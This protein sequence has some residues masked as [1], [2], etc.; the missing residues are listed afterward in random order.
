MLRSIIGKFK[1]DIKERFFTERVISHWNRL[2]RKVFM[3]LRSSWMMLSVIGFGFRKS[4]EMQ[5]VELCDPCG[6][7]QL[8]IFYD[9]NPVTL[10]IS[11]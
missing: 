4:C 9:F 6:P 8:E 1:L 2:P 3:A 10:Y 7:F 11:T 5:G